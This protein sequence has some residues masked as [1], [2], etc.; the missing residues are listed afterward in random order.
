MTYETLMIEAQKVF[1]ISPQSISPMPRIATV[2]LT[3]KGDIYAYVC[4]DV[5]Q[6]RGFCAEHS[7]LT[8]MAAAGNS[9]IIKA[10]SV[11]EGGK[12]EVPCAWWLNFINQLD[13]NNAD[14]EVL[15]EGGVIR[16][17]KVCLP[18]ETSV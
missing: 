9:K 10:A 7:T 5:C 6:S 3:E 13:E 4:N 17:L 1:D 8:A 12:I 15:F 11:W 18:P 16:T 2:L 14:T